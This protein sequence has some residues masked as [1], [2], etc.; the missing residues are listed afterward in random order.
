VISTEA[1]T[2]P[3]TLETRPRP[4]Q[5]AGFNPQ[6]DAKNG[7][8]SLGDIADTLKSVLGPY[9]DDGQV[10]INHNGSWVEVT[11]K[12]ALLFPSGSA[13]LSD[14]AKIILRDVSRVLKP[15]PNPVHVEGY[16][17]NVPINTKAFPSNWEL[18]AAR[19]ASVVH[20]F[21]RFGVD[22]RRLAAV[23]YGEFRPIADNSTE[24]GRRKNRRVTLIIGTGDGNGRD[25]GRG[26][27]R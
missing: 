11:L 2:G 19:A 17:D 5:Q 12:S 4:A 7:Q 23:G 22:P 21:A 3:E 8:R 24:E 18:S 25:P 10:S 20:L 9:V 26:G 16:T 13:D 14:Q 15:L 6:R 1:R 27:K